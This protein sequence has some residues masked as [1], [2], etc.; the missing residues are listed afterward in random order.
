MWPKGSACGCDRAFA[1]LASSKATTTA[2]VADRGDID[3][4]GYATALGDGLA[5]Q[6]WVKPDSPTGQLGVVELVHWHAEL[7]AGFAQGTVVEI[8]DGHVRERAGAS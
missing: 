7:A 4:A 8:R 2:M 6:G 1:G 3:P 5:R